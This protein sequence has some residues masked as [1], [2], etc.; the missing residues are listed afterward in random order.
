MKFRTELTPEALPEGMA[1]GHCL[2]AMGS[3]F[4]DRMGERLAASKFDL[5]SNPL[6][7]A[8]HPLS[9]ARLLSLA[10]DDVLPPLRYAPH[11][12]TWHSFALHSRFN[13]PERRCVEAEVRRAYA[14]VQP[15]LARLDWLLL[16]FGTA[17]AY[18]LREDG[19][20]VNN[21][22]RYPSDHFDLELLEPTAIVAAWRALI[23]RLR[24]ARPH[25]R[26]ICTVSPVRHVRHTLTGNSVSKAVLRLA[27]H[28]LAELP[29][30]AY[31]P[32]FE[33]LTDDLRDYQIGR[34]SCRERV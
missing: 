28:Q 23:E 2:L 33:L 26:V 8:Y 21:N 15:R 34:A 22:H 13:D 17:W 5:V 24:R 29:G 3:C 30:V 16:T 19:Q 18:R 12:A 25:L 27:C 6:G 14:E 20:L 32:A 9:L 11:L 1:H 10:L 4:A 31:F 7:M